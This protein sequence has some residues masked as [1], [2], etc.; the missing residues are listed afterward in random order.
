MIVALAGQGK[1]LYV[2]VDGPMPVICEIDNYMKHY[3]CM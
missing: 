2:T 1:K 3:A